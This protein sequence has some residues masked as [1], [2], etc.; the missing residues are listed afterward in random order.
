MKLLP[1]TLVFKGTPGGRI[2]TQ[3]LPTFPSEG[4]FY[5]CQVKAWLDERV[6]VEWV[7]EVIAPYLATAPPGVVPIIF[8]DSYRCHMMASVVS[9]I[10]NLGC[11]VEHI[12]GGC[13]GNVQPVDVGI[14]RPLKCGARAEWE[15]WMLDE[16]QEKGCIQ[17]PSRRLIATWCIASSKRLTTWRVHLV[18]S[19]L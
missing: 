10:Q 6:M 3:E 13:T 5:K 2:A 12:P 11:E 4:M 7:D 8:L 16:M 18:S 15:Q 9:K 14:N 17:A 1:G 19:R